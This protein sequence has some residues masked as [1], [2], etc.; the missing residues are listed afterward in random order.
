MD[1]QKLAANIVQLV[2]NKENISQLTHCAT[3][4]RFVLK[5]D[6]KADQKAIEALDDVLTVRNS[7]GQFQVVIGPKVA[8]VYEEIAKMTHISAKPTESVP[9]KKKNPINVVLETI[10]GVFTP[11]LPALI[12][13]GLLK[14]LSSIFTTLGWV[15]N[16]S[17]F[18]Q[19]FNMM[20]DVV[21]YFL[22]FFLAVSAARKFKTN[23]FLALALAGAYL[24]PTILDA[25]AKIAETGINSIDFLGMPILLVKYTSSVIPIILSVWILSYVYR[26]IDKYIPDFLRVIVTPVLVLFIMVPLQLVVLG[27][28]GSYAGEWLGQGIGWLFGVAGVFASILL[29]FFR[30]ILVMFGLHYSIMPMQI[31][32]VA[33]NGYT[34]LLPTALAANIAQAGAAFGVFFLTKKK[35]MKSAAGTTGFT[36]L[37]GITEPAMYG[38]N[39]RYKRPFF[40]A[41]AASAIVSGFFA[42][43]HTKGLLIAPP[44]LLTL[45][46]Y[47]ADK[48]FYIII[49]VLLSL[50]LSFIFTLVVGIKEEPQD[51]KLEA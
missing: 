19:I 33:A 11:I 46:G 8:E 5:D 51:E 43:V 24:H 6:K 42:L 37:F 13:C 47:E 49:G 3:R 28:I 50:I 32:E 29:G 44:G 41:C 27:P 10:A 26:Y 20:G 7:G 25:A 14:G 38:V 4:L 48:Y 31:Q 1:N 45:T 30:P 2:G 40:A 34:L 17:G 35:T 18:I 15:D 23:E 9:V 21:F 16:S 12:G 36:A 22:P 39:L